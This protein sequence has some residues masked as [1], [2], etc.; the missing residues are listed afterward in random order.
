MQ[1][2][3]RKSNQESKIKHMVFIVVKQE[4]KAVVTLI[5]KK[6]EAGKLV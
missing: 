2:S 6:V 1:K 3:N 4:E 5:E